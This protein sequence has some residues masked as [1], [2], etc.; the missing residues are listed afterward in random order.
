MIFK[1]ILR[2]RLFIYKTLY[3]FLLVCFCSWSAFSQSGGSDFPTYN[4][5]LTRITPSSPS[6]AAFQK[7]GD[8]PVDVTSGSMQV[9]VPVTTIKLG[10]FNWP[11]SLSYHTNGVKVSDAA[12]EVGLGWVLNANG[13][14]SQKMAG[15]NDLISKDQLDS[16]NRYLDLDSHGGPG[17]C[18]Y[19]ADDGWGQILA[20]GTSNGLPDLFYLKDPLH[21]LKFFLKYNDSGYAMPSSSMKINFN[22]NS[23]TPQSQSFFRSFR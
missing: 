9:T 13:M 5:Y 12:T 17:G 20:G 14:I 19:G 3:S 22:R 4:D 1:L 11:I 23:L 16:M 7:Y 8:I 21:N 18:F 6:A 2:G 10:A 15:V